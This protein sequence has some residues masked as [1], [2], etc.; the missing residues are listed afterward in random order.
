MYQR[1]S[2]QRKSPGAH[3]A[4]NAIPPRAETAAVGAAPPLGETVAF[5]RVAESVGSCVLPGCVVA[6]VEGVSEVPI[7]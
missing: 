6:S 7:V 1:T 5:A 2:S 4:S 3:G